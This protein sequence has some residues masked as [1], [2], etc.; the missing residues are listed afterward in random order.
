MELIVVSSPDKFKS[1]IPVVRDL[2]AA[3]LTTLHVR[4][5]KFSTAKLREYLEEIPEKYHSRI[6]IHT[7]H[8]LAYHFHLKG[9]HFTKHHRKNKAKLF[10]KRTLFRLRK[11]TML[12]TR[13]FHQ[14]ETMRTDRHFYSYAF[15]NPYFSRIEPMKNSFDISNDFLAKLIKESKSPVFASGNIDLNNYHLLQNMNLEG[16]ALSKVIWKYQGDKAALF[17]K[18][19]SEVATW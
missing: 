6:I 19:S 14:I 8:Q 4:K 3:G 15:L 13:S 9:I 1:E 17:Q 5:T 12:M 2:F 18:I 7:H 16:F 10:F 11:P